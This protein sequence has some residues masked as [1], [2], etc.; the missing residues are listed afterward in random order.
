MKKLTLEYNN[1]EAWHAIGISCQL[2]DFKLIFQINKKLKIRFS[3]VE[4]FA[5][6][7]DKINGR[8]SLYTY[9]D[10]INQVEILLL[11]NR[12]E[13]KILLS[14]YKQLD[15]FLIIRDESGDLVLDEYKV[16]I[17]EINE[18]L[19]TQ[20]IEI[21]SVKNYSLFAEAL[22]MHLDSIN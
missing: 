4:D 6:K 15:Y 19:F 14:D 16:K 5:V 9:F 13:S 2:A 17:K 10:T 7:I 12:N 22:E 21:E 11:S 18:V 20:I 3:R 8:F 1:I